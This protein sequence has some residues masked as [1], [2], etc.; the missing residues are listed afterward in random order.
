MSRVLLIDDDR[1]LAQLLRAY[2]LRF[3]LEL[4]AAHHPQEGLARLRRGA[5]GL[6]ILDVMLPDIDGFELCRR[7]RLE[8]D[9]PIIML[10]ARG[11]LSDKVVGLELG[12]DD[13]LAKPFEPRELVARIQALLRRNVGLRSEPRRLCFGG[14][15][16][17]PLRQEAQLDGRPLGLTTMEF[18]LLAL[19]AATPGVPHSRDEILNRLKGVDAELLTRSVDLLVSRLRHKLGDRGRAPRYIK[20]VWGAGYTFIGEPT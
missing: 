19:L 13:Y 15:N 18:Q 9:L 20:T 2:C 14:L 10:T 1:K 11:E 12:A 5:V 6:I 8:S 7:I 16:I 4:E 3:G 17:D